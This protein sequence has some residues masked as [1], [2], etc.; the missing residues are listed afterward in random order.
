MK[1]KQNISGLNMET[2]KKGKKLLGIKENTE[3]E[4]CLELLRVT[5]QKVAKWMTPDYVQI[6][7][8]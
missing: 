7:G 6:N 3:V 4:I 2:E 5:P 8:F 1:M